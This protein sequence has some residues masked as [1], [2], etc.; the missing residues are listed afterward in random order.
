[1]MKATLILLLLLFCIACE[2]YPT[3]KDVTVLTVEGTSVRFLQQKDSNEIVMFGFEDGI[4]TLQD[5][6]LRLGENGPVIIWSLE[7]TAHV[8]DGVVEVHRNVPGAW[9]VKVGEPIRLPG[10]RIDK[11]IGGCAGPMWVISIRR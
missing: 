5:N 7:Y 3:D 8:S 2:T 6:C 1:M 9:A 4:L 10:A 11:D